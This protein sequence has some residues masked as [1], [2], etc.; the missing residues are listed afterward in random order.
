MGADAQEQECNG[1]Y[2]FHVFCGG[3][4]NV[5]ADRRGSG[6][7]IRYS[8]CGLS[9]FSY[10]GLRPSGVFTKATRELKLTL[11]PVLAA[12]SGATEEHVDDFTERSFHGWC[13]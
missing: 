2:S 3:V 6:T 13:F 1:E 8:D 7:Q 12:R 11:R 10:T 4:R 9:Q 5:Y